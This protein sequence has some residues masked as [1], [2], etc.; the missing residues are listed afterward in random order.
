M[1]KKLKK[2]THKK[3][4]K[5]EGSSEKRQEYEKSI[6]KSLESTK[7]RIKP[8]MLQ[9]LGGAFIVI[10]LLV[11]FNPTLSDRMSFKLPDLF[12]RSQ[13]VREEKVDKD[14]KD[15]INDSK[16]EEEKGNI[17]GGASTQRETSSTPNGLALAQETETI[18]NQTGRWRATDYKLN[19]ITKGTYQV[20][21]GDTL[22]E[23]AEAVYGDGTQWT[24]IL[25]ENSSNIGFLPD[26]SQALIVP[27]QFLTIT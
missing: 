23:I 24:K 8:W 1:P 12:N 3:D 16:S 15:E 10:G 25:A 11:L 14:I 5:S 9:L 2:D 4:I 22:W 26:G 13:E 21:L 6:I 27:G 17:A 20:R 7:K 19:D 18:I